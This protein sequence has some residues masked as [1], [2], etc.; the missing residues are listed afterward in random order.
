[1]LVLLKMPAEAIDSFTEHGH[2]NLSRTRVGSVGLVRVD[3]LL[4]FCG[5]ERHA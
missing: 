5:I 1:M 2:L 4:L 3:Q